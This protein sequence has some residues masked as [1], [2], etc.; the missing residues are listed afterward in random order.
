MAKLVGKDGA[1]KLGAAS[2]VGMGTWTL[3]GIVVDELESTEFGDTWKS[4]LY[5]LKDG[6]TVSF[7]GLFDP[8]DS[9][10]AQKILEAN[11]YN[12]ALTNLHFYVDNTSYYTPCQ[13]MGYFSPFLT[14]GAPT[15]TSNLRITTM[16]IG[17]DKSGLGTISFSAKVSGVMVLV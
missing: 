4:Y 2:V 10:G 5:G 13:T 11:L 8:A 1:V 16:N 12:S 3:D 14:T 9:T 7:N 15:K 6:G 17:M